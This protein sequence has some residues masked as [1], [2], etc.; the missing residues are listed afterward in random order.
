MRGVGP[1]LRSAGDG[2]ARKDAAAAPRSRRHFSWRRRSKLWFLGFEGGVGVAGAK[3]EEAAIRG[4]RGMAGTSP[5]TGTARLAA[6]SPA[7]ARPRSQGFG[8]IGVP[9]GGGGPA[10]ARS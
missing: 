4:A 3:E 8:W 2:G 10:V 6:P 5:E 9:T 7:E 1:L